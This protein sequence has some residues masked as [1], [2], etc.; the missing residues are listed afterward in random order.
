MKEPEQIPTERE[1]LKLVKQL[2]IRIKKMDGGDYVMQKGGKIYYPKGPSDMVSTAKSWTDAEKQVKRSAPPEH[3]FDQMKDRNDYEAAI[4][5]NFDHF[6]TFRL[7]TGRHYR[8]TR[9]FMTYP[10]AL[11]DAKKDRK[12]ILYCVSKAGRDFQIPN[13]DYERYLKL[14][15]DKAETKGK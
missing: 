2:G 13:A 9:K 10:E 1:A 14:W 15:Q 11:E 7:H 5:D 3:R 8:D 4:F 12:A 6:K